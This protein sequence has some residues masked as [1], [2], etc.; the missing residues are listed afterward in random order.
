MFCG[1]VSRV[2][3]TPDYAA[4]DV[5]LHASPRV[6]TFVWNSRDS[7]PRGHYPHANSALKPSHFT[8]RHHLGVPRLRS[9]WS[10]LVYSVYLRH[11]RSRQRTRV[12]YRCAASRT[13]GLPH[14][15]IR[16]QTSTRFLVAHT[17][18]RVPWHTLTYLARQHTGLDFFLPAVQ[19]GG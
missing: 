12:A 6:D 4:V 17:D 15:N 5:Y 10:R 3:D 16:C 9:C 1:R 18:S 11:Y 7:T 14:T 8:G 13:L 2:T 19:T